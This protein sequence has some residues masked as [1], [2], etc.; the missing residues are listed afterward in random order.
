[1]GFRLRSSGASGAKKDGKMLTGRQVL[2]SLAFVPKGKTTPK[3]LKRE[4]R[5]L[6]LNQRHFADAPNLFAKQSEKQAACLLSG[7]DRVLHRL[8]DAKLQR[9]F[10]GNLDRCAR[11]RIAALARFSV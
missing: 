4:K 7:K 6:C 2:T 9:S 8:S 3:R 10:R 5:R 11:G 1:L